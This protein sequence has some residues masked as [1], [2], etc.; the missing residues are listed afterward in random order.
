MFRSRVRGPCSGTFTQWY[1]DNSINECLEF[2]FSGCHGNANRFNTKES[3]ESQCKSTRPFHIGVVP[4]QDPCHFPYDQG[5]CRGFFPKYYYS[6]IDNTCKHFIYG[7]CDGNLNRFDT[8]NECENKCRQTYKEEEITENDSVEGKKVF[9]SFQ[10]FFNFV[11]SPK[12][13]YLSTFK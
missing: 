5:P 13:S 1:Y 11:F 12:L 2:L 4:A 8:R 6:S 7:G 9:K 10:I 3:C